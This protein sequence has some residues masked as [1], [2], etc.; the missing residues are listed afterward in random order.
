MWTVQQLVMSECFE[1]LRSSLSLKM[2][3]L[4]KDIVSVLAETPVSLL[5]ME[6]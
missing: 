4:V 1:V 3:V 6:E 5:R 2:I